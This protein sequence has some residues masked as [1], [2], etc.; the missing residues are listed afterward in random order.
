LVVFEKVPFK[1]KKALDPK[2]FWNFDMKLKMKQED[3]HKHYFCVY[4][5]GAED[6]V[7]IL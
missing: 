1:T 4:L 6:S 7:E 5:G 3:Y 2:L